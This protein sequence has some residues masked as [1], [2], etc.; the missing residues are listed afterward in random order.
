LCPAECFD[1]ETP[2]LMWDGTSKRAGDIIIGVILVDDLG[3]PTTVR[4]TCSGFKNMYDVIPDKDNFIKHRVTDNHILTLKIRRHK[5]IRKSDSENKKYTHM[6]EFL[7]R[8][9]V[10]FQR[11]NFRSLKE[12]KIL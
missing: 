3:N 5:S 11:K 2:I 6:V 8:K 1:P 4:T 10:N 9:E 7:N 12:G